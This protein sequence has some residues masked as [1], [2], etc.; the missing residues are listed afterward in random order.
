MRRAI[1][2]LL[3]YGG[4]KLNDELRA[5]DILYLLS[6]QQYKYVRMVLFLCSGLCWVQKVAS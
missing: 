5:E 6:K 2:V 3:D 1:F 4:G